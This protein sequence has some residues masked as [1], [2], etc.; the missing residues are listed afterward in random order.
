[1]K[2][3]G[4]ADHIVE[5]R[6]DEDYELLK[7]YF[8]NEEVLLV[9]EDISEAYPGW[10]VFFDGEVQG[11]WV[12]KNPKITPYRQYI[13]NLCKRFHKIEFRYTLKTQNE[14]V[15]ALATIA[16]MIKH[17][18]DDYIDPLDIEI[19][20]KTVHCSHVEA[21]S[22]SLPW[23][24]DIKKYLE[25]KTYPENPTSNHK[26]SRLGILKCINAIE[27]AKLVEKI[28]VV[29]C[30]THMN[31]LTLAK[32]ILRADFFM[33]MERDSCKFAQECHNCQVHSDLIGVPAHE[34]NALSSPWPFVAWAWM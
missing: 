26:D 30:G 28:H 13:Q 25:S 14:F 17:P 11:E 32:K 22:D 31:G 19:R 2:A 29:V 1:M 16:S 10:R 21:D 6:I 33:T 4:L 9:D 7:T 18:Y 24:L 27:V 8:P 15:D 20:E 5:N 23:Y 12:V 34:L 3:Q